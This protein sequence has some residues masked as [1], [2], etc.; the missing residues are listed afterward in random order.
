VSNLSDRSGFSLCL[1]E[2]GS[3]AETCLPMSVGHIKGNPKILWCDDDPR[4]WGG[5]RASKLSS[6]CKYHARIYSPPNYLLIPCHRP[7]RDGGISTFCRSCVHQVSPVQKSVEWPLRGIWRCRRNI[8]EPTRVNVSQFSAV[9]VVY[10][11]INR[12]S[13]E[14]LEMEFPATCPCLNGI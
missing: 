11:V 2:T 5:G 13:L 14:V 6:A 1:P 4:D 9:S 8:W 10:P 12:R 7:T 3:P